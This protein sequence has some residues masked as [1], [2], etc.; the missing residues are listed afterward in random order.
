MPPKWYIRK[1]LVWLFCL[2]RFECTSWRL[3]SFGKPKCAPKPEPPSLKPA[4]FTPS[5]ICKASL[6]SDCKGLYTAC[7]RS[8]RC[9][10]CGPQSAFL[11]RWRS[12]FEGVLWWCARLSKGCM[13]SGDEEELLG[14]VVRL[15][16]RNIWGLWSVT[17][18]PSLTGKKEALTS[19]WLKLGMFRFKLEVIFGQDRKGSWGRPRTLSCEL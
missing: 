18:K 8:L 2:E 9:N 11:G 14:F 12:L 7:A 4:H 19:F 16:F 10:L 6:S 13:C 3:A 1:G 15:S 5:F 17:E